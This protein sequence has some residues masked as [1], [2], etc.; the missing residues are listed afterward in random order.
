MG[1][2]LICL[3]HHYLFSS[4]PDCSSKED[5]FPLMPPLPGLVSTYFLFRFIVSLFSCLIQALKPDLKLRGSTGNDFVWNAISC[6]SS[7]GQAEALKCFWSSLMPILRCCCLGL[8]S[9]FS[10]LTTLLWTCLSFSY[11]LFWSLGNHFIDIFLKPL[12]LSIL[13]FT[14]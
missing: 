6:C 3:C 14:S 1:F 13:H 11:P 9:P 12:S 4:S 5:S 2:P 10:I 8:W 7:N